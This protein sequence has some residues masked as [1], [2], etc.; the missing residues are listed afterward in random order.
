MPRTHL[1]VCLFLILF[2]IPIAILDFLLLGKNSSG[3]W[4]SLDLT[5]L[6]MTAYALFAVTEII[7]SSIAVAI[8]RNTNMWAIHILSSA[9]AVVLLTAGGYAYSDYQDSASRARYDEE[10][11]TRKLYANVITLDSWSFFPNPDSASGISI[12][13]TVTESGRFAVGATGRDE[14]DYGEWYFQSENEEQRMV[15]KG[16]HFDFSIPIKRERFGVPK[17]I[18]ITLYLFAD[19]T[20]S[21]GRDIVK[22][23]QSAPLTTDDDG[24]YYYS[25]LP[26]STPR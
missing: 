11:E 17:N 3:G 22:T 20:G 4:I 24:Q 14:G 8:F 25:V 16:E 15:G 5:G 9:A 18:E 1:R 7:I 26:N 10:R 6:F 23:F 13:V 2:F 21:A 12:A 19:S